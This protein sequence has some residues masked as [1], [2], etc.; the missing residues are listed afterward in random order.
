MQAS[1]P[2]M[3]FCVCL[4]VSV[5]WQVFAINENRTSEQLLDQYRGSGEMLSRDNP[6][7]RRFRRD[8]IST[9][10]PDSQR[11]KGAA[12]KIRYVDYSLIR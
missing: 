5:V 3:T 6:P 11:L 10:L 12:Q 1:D 9:L 2:I 7:A 4:P 8:P